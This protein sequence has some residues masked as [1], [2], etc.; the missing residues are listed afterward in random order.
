MANER[1]LIFDTSLRDGEQAPGCSMT[2]DE[3]LRVAHKLENL[4][5]DIIEA[6]FPIASTGD[7]E[8]VQ[9]ISRE[10]RVRRLPRWRAAGAKIFRWRGMPCATHVT[11]AFIPF[12]L[13]PIFISPAS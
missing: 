2:V 6:G 10:M 1:V 12:W 13:P 11:R 7:F 3:K 4:G 8:A 5:V 9:R